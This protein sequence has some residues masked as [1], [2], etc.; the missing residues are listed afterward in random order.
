MCRV[1]LLAQSP[2]NGFLET[3]AEKHACVRKMQKATTTIIH[4]NL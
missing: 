1:H 4:H 2:E 3:D